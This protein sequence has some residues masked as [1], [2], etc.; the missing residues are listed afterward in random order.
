VQA[1]GGLS[2]EQITTLVSEAESNALEDKRRR[3]SAEISNKA[4]GLVYSTERTLEEY[5][6]HVSDEDRQTLLV[7][8]EKTK[9]TLAAKDYDSLAVAVDELSALSYQLT[10][11]L[12]AALGS[13][14][15]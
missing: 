13:K 5:A 10:E 7:A 12:Y 11:R 4:D 8:L 2:A 15:E 6:Q 3:D 14:T 1:S 9:A